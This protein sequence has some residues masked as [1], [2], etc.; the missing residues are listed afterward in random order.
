M[1]LWINGPFG[2]GKTATAYELHR[3]LPGSVVCDPAYVGFGMRRMLPA[4]L[5]S[6][7]QDL[8]AWRRS[9]LELLQLTLA[10]YAGPVIVPMTLTDAGYFDQIVG[11][12]RDDGFAV[13][14]VALLAEPVTVRRRL[15][16]RSLGLEARP[17]SWALAGLN[18]SLRR[19]AEPRFAQ[20]I[21]TDQRTV[22]QVAEAVAGTAGLAIAPATGG[23][24]RATGRRYLTTIRHIRRG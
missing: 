12:L 11:A 15:R 6:N 22:A 4:S 20:Q 14:H 21:H 5:R 10:G 23:P 24:L 8:P 13:C 18:E 19:L 3:R 9:V 16:A 17:G 1:L 7:F 2:G